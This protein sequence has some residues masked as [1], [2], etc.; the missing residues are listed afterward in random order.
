MVSS[1][2]G[3]RDEQTDRYKTKCNVGGITASR[4]KEQA[5]APRGLP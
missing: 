4:K 1:A 5:L 2:V 3:R